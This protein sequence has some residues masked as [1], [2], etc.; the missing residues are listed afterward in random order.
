MKLLINYGLFI[1]FFVIIG[2]QKQC[3]ASY[4]SNCAAVI[5]TNT[6]Y[7]TDPGNYTFSVRDTYHYQPTSVETGSP[8]IKI[9]A[10]DIVVD[11]QDIGIYNKNALQSG[12]IGIEIGWTPEELIADSSRIQPRNIIIKNLSLYDFDCGLIV[13][14]GVSNIIIKNCRFFDTAAGILILGKENSLVNRVKLN[15]INI[16]DTEVNYH[17]ALT[18]LKTIIETNYG[19]GAN[20]WMTL[21]SDPFNSNALDVY[22]YF[23]IWINNVMDLCLEE[24]KINGIGY[25][26]YVSMSEGDGQRTVAIGCVLKNTKQIAMKNVMISGSQSEIKAV[27]MQLDNCFD[28]LLEDSSFSFQSS[29][30]RAVGIEITNVTSAEYSVEAL[31]VKSIESKNNYGGEV[32]IGMDLSS[33][34]GVSGSDIT[35]KLNRGG[36]QAYGIYANNLYTV[37]LKNGSVGENLAT[38][39]VNNLATNQGITSAGFYGINVNSMQLRKID[40]NSMK[41][42]NSS[43]GMYLNNSSSIQCFECLFVANVA[44]MMRSGE[45]VDIR[46][47]QDS[48]EISKYGPVV[49]ATGT[50]AYG[51]YL[52]NCKFIKFDECTFNSQTGH[53][54]IGLCAKNSRALALVN[55]LASTQF[56]T[57]LMFDSTLV[58]NNAANPTAVPIQPAHQ[59]L[60]FGDSS[61]TS[62]DALTTTDLFLTKMTAIRAAQIAG[63]T[64]TYSDVVAM[65]STASLLQAMVAR[66][67]LWSVAFGVY[68]YNVTGVLIKDMVCVGN[69]SMFDNGVGICCAGRNADIS[70]EDTAMSFNIGGIVSMQTAA[71]SPTAQYKYKYNLIGLKAFWAMLT[72][73]LT[74]PLPLAADGDDIGF[75][76]DSTHFTAQGNKDFGDGTTGDDVYVK[77]NGTDHRVMVSP[78]GPVG[79]GL[80]MGDFVLEGLVKNSILYGNQGTAG[81]A[82]GVVLDKAI[83]VTLESCNI[84]GSLSNIY[85]YTVGALDVTTHSLNLYMNNFLEG[86]KCSVFNNANYMIPFNPLDPNGL[87]FPVTNMYNGKF[88]NVTTMSDNIVMNYS[89]DSTAYQ[90]ESLL[91][92]PVPTDIR[93]Y[94]TTNSC[95]S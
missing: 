5:S 32:G 93:S 25:D 23:G 86:N 2:F 11:F 28:V 38:G 26:N 21:L 37:N 92:N 20:Y 40:C 48:Q 46:T 24:I 10:S 13:H 33:V 54:A 88:S 15:E 59:S 77:L 55:C 71:T 42:L 69:I 74:T 78:V 70:V 16:T 50:G 41:A 43:Y 85:G 90:V 31:R 53:R 47:Q 27:G 76:S 45:A 51:A 22:S 65:I 87:A 35:S 44:T 4:I 6:F 84:A 49:A 66:Y 64:P 68:F 94:L 63:T 73:S 61:K 83:S 60:L 14:E 62:V 19:Y 3:G 95:W 91:D 12:W 17:E 18:N 8:M 30:I 82:F 39:S 36:K 89:Q 67:R 34:R 81:G 7:I 56:A 79:A 80:V 75:L 57:G 58:T 72:T 9:I 1:G 52:D 29:A